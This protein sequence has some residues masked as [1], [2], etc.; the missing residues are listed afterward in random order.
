[1]AITRYAPLTIHLSGP[2]V[3]SNGVK[4]GAAGTAIAITSNTLAN[5]TVVTTTTPHGFVTGN[6]VTISG[7]I[8]SAPTI[9]S[10]YT[11]TVTGASTF[12]VPVNV[13]TAG[14]GG[15]V[16]LSVS[17]IAPGM[18]IERYSDAGTASFR[19]HSVAGGSTPVV[20]ALNASM[21]NKGV[22]LPEGVVGDNY[23]TADL[24]EAAI[25]DKGAT[26]WA[27]VATAA[28]AI[29][30]GDKLE[31]AG[32]GTLRKYIA[33]TPIAVSLEALTNTSGANAHL[34]VEIL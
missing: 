19:P 12:T 29:A 11:V 31:S 23:G 34:K 10:T 16:G 24:V 22:G 1:M 18:L 3:L 8:T 25:P 5:P 2:I 28:P 9:N 13:T 14:T 30:I 33:G 32:N 21:L 4:A 27:L 15:S 7:V 17:A 20:F 26:I 6:V